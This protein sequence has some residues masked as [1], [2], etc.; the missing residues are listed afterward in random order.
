MKFNLILLSLVL[1][2]PI[3][4]SQNS[5]KDCALTASYPNFFTLGHYVYEEELMFVPQV[6]EVDSNQC[7]A[8][9]FNQHIMKIDYLLTNYSDK[10]Y[11]KELRAMG[12]PEKASDLYITQLQQDT[13]FNTLISQLFYRDQLEAL[14]TLS[15]DAVMSIAVKFFTVKAINEKG[16]YS[17]QVCAGLNLLKATEEQSLPQVEAFCF[18]TIYDSYTSKESTLQADFTTAL[19]NLYKIKLG[20]DK[21]ERLLRAQGMMFTQMFN[22]EQLRLTLKNNYLKQQHDLPFV[23]RFK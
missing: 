5:S 16:Y 17:G 8:D 1:I 20:L 10:S 15:F 22:N 6:Q 19:K 21:E 11:F 13:E 4:F 7:F 9:V 23:I 3:A 12:E 2:S 18:T 14:D